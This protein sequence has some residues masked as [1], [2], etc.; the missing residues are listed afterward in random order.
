MENPKVAEA[1]HI[2]AVREQ[3]LLRN[4]KITPV[5]IEKGWKS[6]EKRTLD[7]ER[8]ACM[9]SQ[10]DEFKDRLSDPDE[11]RDSTASDQTPAQ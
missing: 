10:I 8:L 2:E 11:L 1:A 3:W 5:L 9:Y 6:H 4:N 7:I